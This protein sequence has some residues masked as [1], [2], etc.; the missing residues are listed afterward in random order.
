MLSALFLFLLP[1]FDPA[2]A[3]PQGEAESLALPT[4][5]SWRGP[6]QTGAAD[7]E[8]PTHWSEE[9]NIAWKVP[10]PGHGKS[11]PILAAGRI[12]LQ[13][14]VEA[15]AASPEELAA[16]PELADQF[17]VPPTDK[18]VFLVFALDEASGELLWETAVTERLPIGGNHDT[19]GFASFSP[20]TDGERVYA[21][22]GSQGVYALDAA[23]GAVLWSYELGPQRTRRGWGEAGSP[24]LHGN[25]LLVLADQED[26]SRLHALD[27]KTGK[28][29]WIVERDEPSTWTTPL[30]V[31]REDTTYAII[32]GS[33][34]VRAYDL[35]NGAVVWHCTGQTLNAIPSVV[36]ADGIAVSMSGFRG[37]AAM[38]FDLDGR[39]DLMGTEAVLWEHD[40]GTPYVPSP[41]LTEGR[42]YFL[43]G[44][45]GRLSCIELATGELLLD[46]E[47]LDLGSVYASPIAAGGRIFVT[48]RDGTTV[49]L[50]HEDELEVLATNTLDDPIDASPVASGSRLYLRSD[51]HLY[52][53]EEN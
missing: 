31:P 19:N 12:Y 15:G 46:R 37:T 45:A 16:R 26:Q 21:S 1:S 14:A 5:P 51:H 47:R 32:N 10:L 22:F 27:T 39:G 3:A 52:A 18:Y 44:N 11:T 6:N 36:A 48:G 33:T 2:P 29:R 9:K 20:V 13:A 42:V 30:I 24:A 40:R 53:I 23:S 4:W 8:P 41:L 25:T 49:V 7:A 34:A 43:G 17:T 28:P 50:R 35:K 38:A